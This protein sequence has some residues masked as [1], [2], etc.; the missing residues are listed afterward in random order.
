MTFPT[1]IVYNPPVQ[2]TVKTNNKGVAIYQLQVKAINGG[3]SNLVL[4]EQLFEANEKITDGELRVLNRASEAT[5]FTF[6]AD[7]LV[8]NWRY[9][10][11][12]LSTVTVQLG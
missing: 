2:V 8:L 7:G 9:A 5:P 10:T 11:T 3:G 1:K 12:G 6:S 4:S